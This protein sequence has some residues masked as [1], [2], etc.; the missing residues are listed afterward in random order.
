MVGLSIGRKL[1]G[2]IAYSS[3][4][5][6]ARWGAPFTVAYVVDLQHRRWHL[7]TP[8]AHQIVREYARHNRHNGVQRGAEV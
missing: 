3:S 7:W 8:P 1:L 5:C 4:G 2:I 6:H